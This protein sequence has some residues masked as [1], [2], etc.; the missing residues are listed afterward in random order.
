VRAA[1]VGG[2]AV[3]GGYD[4]LSDLDLDVLCRPGTVEA[5]YDRILTAVRLGFAPP[6][7]WELP[8]ANWPDGR[9]CFIHLLERPGLLSSPTQIID[10]HLSEESDAHRLID[11]R[12]HGRPRVLHD[13]HRIIELVPE[14]A[15]LSAGCALAL[16]QIRQQRETAE[17]RISSGL[18]PRVVN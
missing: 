2:S 6:D 16:D 5:V 8:L 10:L 12:R 13:P 7:I 4:D 1:W 15:T 3:T 9:Q 18:V 14:D 17:C 11:V